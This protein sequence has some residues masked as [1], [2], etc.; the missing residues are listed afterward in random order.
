MSAASCSTSADDAEPVLLEPTTAEDSPTGSLE[1][2]FTYGE[3]TSMYAE[4]ARHY[5][6]V[7]DDAGAVILR[8]DEGTEQGPGSGYSDTVR[9]PPGDYWVVTFQRGC[10]FGQGTGCET[11]ADP[12]SDRCATDVSLAPSQTTRVSITL[13]LPHPCQ[14]RVNQDADS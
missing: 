14:V 11:T 8:R 9:L 3:R 6:Q 12:A 13:S 1:V 4:G 5:L 10:D 2:R 7:L